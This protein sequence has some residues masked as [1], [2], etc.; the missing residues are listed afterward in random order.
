M[1]ANYIG[2]VTRLDEALRAFDDSGMPMAP[3]SGPEPYPWTRE[4]VEIITTVHKAFGDVID[5][6][7]T[8]DAHRREH[9][10]GLSS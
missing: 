9:L 3:G 2:A 6:R 7:R 4:Q 10:R 1:R 5:A 8:W